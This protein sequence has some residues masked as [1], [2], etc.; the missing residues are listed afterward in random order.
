M[1]SEKDKKIIKASLNRQK[2]AL[3]DSMTQHKL[4]HSGRYIIKG[5]QDDI[6]KIEEALKKVK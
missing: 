5:Y 4:A 6:D 2:S 1:L 3:A